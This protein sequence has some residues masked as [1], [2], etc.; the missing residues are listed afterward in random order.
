MLKE[1]KFMVLKRVFFSPQRIRLEWNSSTSWK[2]SR[3]KRLS[4]NSLIQP[5]Q[6]EVSRWGGWSFQTKLDKN[7]SPINCDT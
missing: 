2:V 7:L 4:D 6:S 3:S 5:A 1:I